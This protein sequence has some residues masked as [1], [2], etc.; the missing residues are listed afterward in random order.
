MKDI[1]NRRL[2]LKLTGIGITS[3][4]LETTG[5]V[6][7]VTSDASNNPKSGLVLVN[8]SS[9]STE[10]SVQFSRGKDGAG[11]TGYSITETL[12]SGINPTENANWRKEI[13]NV[14]L[15]QGRYYVQV[16]TEDGESTSS[17]IILASEDSRG[18]QQIRV[19]ETD[20]RIMAGILES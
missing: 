8:H 1:I 9:T 19:R 10:L 20:R 12:D 17:E 4:V 16:S 3:N 7:A 11:T 2:I 5:E 6:G 14:P 18:Y 15:P 13:D